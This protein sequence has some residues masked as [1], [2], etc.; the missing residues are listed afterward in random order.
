MLRVT[1]RVHTES[2]V[3]KVT[4]GYAVAGLNNLRIVSL[5]LPQICSVAAP[6]Y[7]R[8]RSAGG[9]RGAHQQQASLELSGRGTHQSNHIKDQQIRRDFRPR[10][11]WTSL[12]LAAFNDAADN[13]LNGAPP[14]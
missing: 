8:H 9:E 2:W 13:A 5:S 7:Q 12:N 4:E 14:R 10:G 3:R 11:L 1:L 6:H